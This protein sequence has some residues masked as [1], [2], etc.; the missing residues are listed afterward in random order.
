MGWIKVKVQSL[1][2]NFNSG[3]EVRVNMVDGVITLPL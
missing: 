3:G 1:F 2:L